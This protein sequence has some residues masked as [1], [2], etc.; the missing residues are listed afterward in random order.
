MQYVWFH[1]YPRNLSGGAR[2]GGAVIFA[3]GGTITV[4]P[5]I[6][7]ELDTSI[8]A[9]GQEVILSGGNTN[10]VFWVSVGKKLDLI[11]LTIT[12]AADYG[13]VRNIGGTVTLTNCL[14]TGNTA[15]SGGGIRNE[16]STGFGTMTLTNTTVSGN[17]ASDFGGGIYNAGKMTLTNGTVSENTA[18]NGVGGIH[19][20]KNSELQDAGSIT[21]TN[22]TVSDNVGG[23][24]GGI[25]NSG[26][27]ALLSSTVSGNSAISDDSGNGGGI[28][29]FS[30]TGTLTLTNSTVSGNSATKR[31]GGI[32]AYN[33]TITIENS[34]ISN[35]HSDWIGGG[36]VSTVDTTLTITNST[37]SGNSANERGGGIESFGGPVTITNSTLSGNTA[38]TLGGGIYNYA[39][40][41]LTHVTFSGNSAFEGSSLYVVNN[42][43]AATQITNT[44]IAT[45]SAVGNCVDD[46]NLIT[47]FG[48]N[49]SS[50]NTCHLTSGISLPNTNPNLGL[51]ADNGGPTQTH[52]LLAGSPAIDKIPSGANGC[53]TTITTDQRG[54]AR[55]QGA[56]CDIGAYEVAVVSDAWPPTVTNVTATPNPTPPNAAVTLTATLDDTTTGNSNIASAE[57]NVDSGDD[58]TSMN[59]TD[60]AFN[61]PLESVTATLTFAPSQAG[62][63]TLCVRG[64]DAFANTSEACTTVNVSPLDNTPPV[65]TPTVSGTLG[66]NGWY[67]SDVAVSWAVV[68]N[69]S[70]ITSKVGC[71]PATVADDTTGVTFTCTATSS[72]GTAS[73]S[74]TIQRDATAPT[75]SGSASPAANANGWNNSAVTVSFT[76]NDATS[77][78]AGCTA[79]QTLGQG[80]NQSASGT[81]TDN[82]GHTASTQVTGINVDLTAP[83]VSVT[84]VINNVTYTLGSVPTAGCETSDALSGVQTSATSSVTGGNADGTG[85]FTASCSGA[86]DNADNPGSASVTYQVISTPGTFLFNSFS[87]NSIRINQRLNTLFLLSNFTLGQGS[88]GI[89]PMTEPVTLRI[90]N[91]AIAN[92]TT[93]IPAGSFRKGRTGAYAFAGR[94]NNVLIEAL[95]VPLGNNRFGF[96]AA[97]YGANLSGTTNPVTVGIT[98]GNDNGTTSVN[99]IIR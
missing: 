78:I 58:W 22:S 70:A 47:D 14:V 68:D 15:N 59:A 99:A 97:A 62:T 66:N 52:A 7:I 32:H 45:S 44:L 74:V 56:N 92:F 82:A 89:N 6:R 19:N 48:Y 51:L 65:I 4:V 27:L 85:T 80:A 41:F 93:T 73:Q 76:C 30:S 13:G 38:G 31:G 49:L 1:I 90:A 28:G 88:D 42:N 26:Q 77:D 53:G 8:D 57:Y 34:T 12:G 98:I 84:G 83:M 46:L 69:E 63:R 29:V 5:Q 33:G 81:A 64:T 35:N 40:L 87:V 96:Q 67:T 36:I 54:V 94:I 86:T 16:N 24:S 37:I 10:S 79:P 23:S 9:N 50:D 18:T 25:F 71:D 2:E 72:G 20:I 55:P 61:S 95:I 43:V 3:C 75:I 39:P 21:L 17:S 11:G 60:G 91:S